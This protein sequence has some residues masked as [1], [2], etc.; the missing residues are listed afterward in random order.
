MTCLWMTGF[1]T[2]CGG[3]ETENSPFSSLANFSYSTSVF[4][5]GL[6]SG[7]FTGTGY[8]YAPAEG[9]TFNVSSGYLRTYLLLSSTTV[10]VASRIMAFASSLGHL[11]A[12]RLR[13]DRKL[14]L[15]LNGPPGPM[16]TLV[17]S[18]SA[19]AANTWYCLELH[20][21]VTGLRLAARLDGTVWASGLVGQFAYANPITYIVLGPDEATTTGCTLYYD[22]ARFNSGAGQYNCSWPGPLGAGGIVLLVP[23]A[24]G[25][26]T[27][28]VAQ[29]G[30]TAYHEQ[31]DDLPSSTTDTTTYMKETAGSNGSNFDV[32][33][34]R[35]PALRGLVSA[36][37][38]G[39]RGG[40]TAATNRST[41]TFLYD[42]NHTPWQGSTVNW[43][44]NGWKT[45]YP[46]LTVEE[47]W[48]GNPR[49]LTTDYL[50]GN[51]FLSL[52]GVPWDQSL[53]G[54]YGYGAPGA[55]V[56][57][58]RR[59][60]ANPAAEIRI[61]AYWMSCEVNLLYGTQ[62]RWNNPAPTIAIDL[63]LP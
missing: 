37:L 6:R 25:T 27:S 26:A 4:R 52:G 62:P 23:T 19:L 20:V 2:A 55:N 48:D 30:G 28:W 8:V 29:A 49:P 15:I 59:E 57:R 17:V 7:V 58:T 45:V 14:E 31:L 53:L 22:D 43:N 32:Y 11:A 54:A 33:F 44:L 51:A 63:D 39:V 1:E 61:T 13:T 9:G 21:D 47:A 50:F 38:V 35:R 34:S 10:G 36:A 12:I 42:P 5:S 24:S 40:G 46:V 56:L 60:D 41:T 18:A 16:Q 3:G